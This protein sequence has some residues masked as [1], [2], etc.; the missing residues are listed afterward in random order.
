MEKV[1]RYVK[2][3]ANLHRDETFADEYGRIL[4]RC[5]GLKHRVTVHLVFSTKKRFPFLTDKTVRQLLYDELSEICHRLNCPSLT[6]GGVEDHVHILYRLSP[7]REL[8]EVSREIKKASS[9]SLATR[10]G[11][12]SFDWQEGYGAFSVSPQHEAAVMRYIENQE[13]HHRNVSFVEECRLISRRTKSST[14]R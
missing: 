10:H 9:I 6:V 3:Q 13:E 4:Q 1:I 5:G 7:Q 8:A 11:I 14:P 12:R 2:N